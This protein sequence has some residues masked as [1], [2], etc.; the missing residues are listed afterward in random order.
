WPFKQLLTPLLAEE[1]DSTGM[2]SKIGV[3]PNPYHAL[4]FSRFEIMDS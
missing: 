4:L 2:P 1:S 3:T